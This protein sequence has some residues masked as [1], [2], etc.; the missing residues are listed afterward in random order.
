MLTS[1]CEKKTDSK[2]GNSGSRQ[3]QKKGRWEKKEERGY[4]LVLS[5]KKVTQRMGDALKDSFNFRPPQDRFLDPPLHTFSRTSAGICMW[6]VTWDRRGLAHCPWLAGHP[7]N[8]SSWNRRYG[9]GFYWRLSIQEILARNSAR[10]EVIPKYILNRES[11]LKKLR[12]KRE[13]ILF[14]W[15]PSSKGCSD[16]AIMEMST[17]PRKFGRPLSKKIVGGGTQHL[18]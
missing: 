2:R 14:N 15:S 7:Q 16:L 5:A 12:N 10:I 6:Q 17:P 1:V 13:D 18:Y 11:V 4:S 8:Q 9:T 3:K